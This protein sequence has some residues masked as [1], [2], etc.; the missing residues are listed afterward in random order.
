MIKKR[1]KRYQKNFSEKTRALFLYNYQCWICGQNTWDALHHI[2]GGEFEEADSPLNAA[3]I[4]NMTCHI[5]DGHH[6]TEEDKKMMC[7]KT[8]RFLLRNGYK[9]TKKDEKFILD[10]IEYYS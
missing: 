2:F 8:L 4:C 5:G 7:Q 10:H 3:P 1:V 9:L 6:F